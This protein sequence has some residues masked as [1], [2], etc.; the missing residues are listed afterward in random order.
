MMHFINI[1]NKLLGH[2]ILFY[3]A[4]VNLVLYSIYSKYNIIFLFDSKIQ[5]LYWTYKKLCKFKNQSKSFSR[6]II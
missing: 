3:L 5:T 1:I 4:K 6:K 2:T